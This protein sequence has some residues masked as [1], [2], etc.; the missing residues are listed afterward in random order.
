M[1]LFS[2]VD[3]STR[4]CGLLILSMK[5]IWRVAAFLVAYFWTPIPTQATVIDYGVYLIFVLV[6]LRQI[7]LSHA[8]LRS[9]MYPHQTEKFSGLNPNNIKRRVQ[10]KPGTMPKLI[11]GPTYAPS[12]PFLLFIFCAWGGQLRLFVSPVVSG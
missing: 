10:L 6:F 8:C 3:C 12:H 11:S 1:V 5:G 4:N 2:V 9:Y 7:S